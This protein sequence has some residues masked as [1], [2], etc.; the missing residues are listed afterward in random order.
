MSPARSAAYVSGG[1]SIRGRPSA[2][3]GS[4]L[5]LFPVSPWAFIP[6]QE[7]QGRSQ[8]RKDLGFSQALIFFSLDHAATNS[9]SFTA[10]CVSPVP[11]LVTFL[12]VLFYCVT[13]FQS[14][15]LEAHYWNGK[16]MIV[17]H[18]SFAAPSPDCCVNRRHLYWSLLD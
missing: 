4:C 15:F 3:A 11:S 7:S 14:P 18:P 8:H 16:E 17:P 9:Y 13:D 10:F 1:S 5:Q 2:W 12:S 6:A